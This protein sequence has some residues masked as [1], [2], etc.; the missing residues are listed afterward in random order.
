MGSGTPQISPDVPRRPGSRTYFPG[1]EVAAWGPAFSH[2]ARDTNANTE[3]ADR[4][5]TMLSLPSLVGAQDSCKGPN[6]L[7]YWSCVPARDVNPTTS[8]DWC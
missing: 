8:R 2:L 3:D 5:V 1:P 4:F 7:C 6:R